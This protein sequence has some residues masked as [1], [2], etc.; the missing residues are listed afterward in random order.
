MDGVGM[1]EL[2]TLFHRGQLN[3]AKDAYE[4]IT[5]CPSHK[6]HRSNFRGICMKSWI[7]NGVKLNLPWEK[8][9]SLSGRDRVHSSCYTQVYVTTCLSL[10]SAR[11]R[12]L[13]LFPRQGLGELDIISAMEGRARDTDRVSWA[14]SRWSN[15][16]DRHFIAHT[17][18]AFYIPTENKQLEATW[19]SD[20]EGGRFFTS[21]VLNIPDCGR[22]RTEVKQALYRIKDS[23]KPSTSCKRFTNDAHA[24]SS[25]F[26]SPT[27]R[28]IQ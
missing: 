2:D 22:S 1:A 25:F 24:N 7:I 20:F 8:L 28:T 12:N 6:E 23:H 10:I 19:S 4:W 26:H 5:E 18:L 3:D 13:P 17:M 21:C 16:P 9:R 15:E 14:P 11:T 27:K